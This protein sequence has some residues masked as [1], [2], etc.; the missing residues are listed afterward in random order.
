MQIARRAVPP[1][2]GFLEAEERL[3]FHIITI[4][5]TINGQRGS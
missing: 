4:Y 2:D 5:G 3:F 1:T